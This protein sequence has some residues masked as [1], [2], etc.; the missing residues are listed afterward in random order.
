MTPNTKPVLKHKLR[1]DSVDYDIAVDVKEGNVSHVK[2][3]V[4]LSDEDI[5][6][7]FAKSYDGYCPA[8]LAHEINIGEIVCCDCY[9]KAQRFHQG[10]CGCDPVMIPKMAAD[11]GPYI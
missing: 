10:T 6:T 1:N 3:N 5:A 2:L 7:L 8:C 4:I 11:C 9:E